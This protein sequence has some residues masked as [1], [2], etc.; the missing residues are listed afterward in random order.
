MIKTLN[1]L[2]VEDDENDAY[3]VK[4]YLASSYP[5]FECKIIHVRTS[6][7]GLDILNRK[8]P[9]S[10][11]I[12]LLDLNLPDRKGLDC[13]KAFESF[14]S[15]P[16]IVVTGDKNMEVGYSAI[17]CGAW[18]FLFKQDL[19]KSQ[20]IK[21]I[22]FTEAR[23]ETLQSEVK[24]RKDLAIKENSIDLLEAKQN[25][26]Q[27]AKDS[28]TDLTTSLAIEKEIALKASSN[29]SEANKLLEQ[30][31]K[32]IE[33]FVFA[34][35]HDLK[36]PLV[37][38]SGFTDLTLEKLERS[39]YNDIKKSL[40]RIKS[41]ANNM[42]STLKDLLNLYKILY[43]K[44][45]PSVLDPISIIQNQIALLEDK[46]TENNVTIKIN[47][48][49]YSILANEQLLNQCIFNLITNAI[50]YRDKNRPLSLTFS[51]GQT[52]K[53][54]WL[55]I[56]DNGIGIPEEYHSKI[57]KLFERLATTEGSGIGLAIVKS[58]M[59]RHEGRITIN[60]IVGEGSTFTLYFPRTYE[61][62][63]ATPRLNSLG[64]Q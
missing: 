63:P 49:A 26:L 3:L 51:F 39:E 19:D 40:L 5:F 7:E 56:K 13:I 22:Y 46:I 37:S 38:I 64:K 61:S 54:T 55:A 32:E 31:N 28:L 47:T 11:D 17:Q 16:I 44:P 10:I 12:I 35:S 20:L 53:E 14:R 30:K 33:Q 4:N 48:P 58:A 50:L 21:S 59:D 45:T 29:L 8:I 27:K 52:E 43:S 41:N 9:P 24:V 42:N 23:F 15:S 18:D 1:I 60:S 34:V 6:Q 36:S 62:K 25:E 57:F 2:L